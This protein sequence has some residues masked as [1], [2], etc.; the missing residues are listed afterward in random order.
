MATRQT[1][2]TDRVAA[3]VAWGAIVS[4]AALVVV[5]LVMA[6]DDPTRDTT[7]GT[8]TVSP[9]G[10]TTTYQRRAEP[11]PGPEPGGAPQVL[12][13]ADDILTAYNQRDSA[14]LRAWACNR[15][16]VTDDLFAGFSDTVTFA[17]DGAP[18]IVAFTAAV[19][20]VVSD[21]GKQRSGAMRLRWDGNRWCFVTAVSEPD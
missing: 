5:M 20:F 8:T 7:V 1:P 6:Q 15:T 17:R 16:T 10:D 2:S 11:L 12:L 9:S 14:P 19:P 4:A 3:V 13:A 21:D 18:R